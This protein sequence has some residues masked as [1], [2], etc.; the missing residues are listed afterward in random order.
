MGR[1]P[2]KTPK[3]TPAPPWWDVCVAISDFAGAAIGI[4]FAATGVIMFDT[5]YTADSD[6]SGTV[7]L[8]LLSTFLF[9]AGV[10][11][12]VRGMLRLVSAARTLGRTR[13]EPDSADPKVEALGK[14]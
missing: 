10:S 3:D 8:V 5:I 14:G 6:T 7:F 11:M 12:S 2:E 4:L 9:V 13:A 1:P